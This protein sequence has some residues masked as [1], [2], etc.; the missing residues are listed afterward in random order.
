VLMTRFND[1]GGE[2]PG[3]SLVASGRRCKGRNVSAG[4]GGGEVGRESYAAQ[5]G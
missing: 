5:V 2:I 1:G 3:F 4:R